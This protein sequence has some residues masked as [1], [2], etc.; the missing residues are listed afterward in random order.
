MKQTALVLFALLVIAL[1]VVAQEDSVQ[2]T[3]REVILY[4]GTSLP[5]LPL[6]FR[7]YWKNGWNAGVGYGYSF[8][9]GSFGYGAVYATVDYS[10]FILN[11]TA[12]R[13]S[14][15]APLDQS[16][17]PPEA[18]ALKTAPISGGSTKILTV[19]LNFKGSFAATKNS[20]APYFLLGVGYMYYSAED[21]TADTV[22]MYRIPGKTSSA[23]GWTFGIGVEASI[24][25]SIGVFVQGK[26]VLGVV[27]KTRQYFPLSA[28]VRIRM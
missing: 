19:M 9:P 17:L 22:Q 11:G 1:P 2:Q 20:I 4:G 16:N 13:D 23:F 28:G 10:R 14:M 15:L 6:E 26:S 25:E 8:A 18:A 3:D 24:T 7:T 27:D 21:V 5:Y 12:Y